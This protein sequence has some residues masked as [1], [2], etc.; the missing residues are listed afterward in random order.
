MCEGN[1]ES[2]D[3]GKGDAWLQ[4]CGKVWL[5]AEPVSTAGAWIV[6]PTKSDDEMTYGRPSDAA[7]FDVVVYGASCAGVA[8][9]V[10]AGQ[11]GMKVGLFEPLP[12]IGGMCAAGNLALHDS[13]P[14]GGLGEVYAKL[15]AEYY[16]VT[17]PIS[18]PESFVSVRSFNTMLKNASVTHVRLDCHLTAAAKAVAAD[19]TSKV[20]SISVACEEEPVTATVFIDASYDGEVMVAVGDVEYTAGRE[21]IAQYNG[22]IV[23]RFAC[24]PSR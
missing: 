12:M 16:N 19:G 9:A 11:L 22:K 5:A 3:P 13:G 1:G 17:K 10:A 14:A 20:K 18:Q 23:M 21:S 4:T 6:V 8:A 2:Y 7:Q 15:N 24:C